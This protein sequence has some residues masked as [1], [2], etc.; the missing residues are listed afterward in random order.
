MRSAIGGWV[1]KKRETSCARKGFAIIMCELL[2]NCGVGASGAR[3]VPVSSF[4]RA[5]A[6]ARGSPVSFAPSSSASYSRVRLI[7]IWITIAAKGARSDIP[8]RAIGLGRSSSLPPP[9]KSAICA[10]E[11]ITPARAPA[12]EP[13]RMSRL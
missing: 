6:S 5:D 13:V 2:T 7:A 10:T 8:I 11:V 3:R 1:A 4:C 9:K 12:I